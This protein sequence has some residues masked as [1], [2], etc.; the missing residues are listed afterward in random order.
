MRLH[1]VK[2]FLWACLGVAAVVIVARLLL[3]LG[4][5]TALTDA[6]PWGLW[7]GF[8]VLGGVALAAG[9]FVIAASVH[10]FHLERYRPILRPAILTAFLGYIAVA[11][12]LVFDIGVPWNI[13]RPMLFW[14]PNSALFEVAWCVMLYLS[15]LALEFSPVVL[16]R[17]PFTKVLALLKKV[18]IPLVILGVMLSTLH[19]SSL[20]TLF[21]LMPARL[22]PLWYSPLL[23]ILFLVSA[24]GLGLCTVMIESAVTSWLFRK[25]PETHL[26]S[27]LARA[28]AWVLGSYA[29]LRIGDLAV[30]GALGSLFSDPRE[31]VLFVL[32]MGTGAVL[33]IALFVLP[34]TQN[35]PAGI[36]LASVSAVLGFVLNR[37]N[38]CGLLTTGYVPA[39]TEVAITL[40]VLAGAALAFLF[41]AE[42]FSVYESPR[43][44]S[45]S[46]WPEGD[47]VTGVRLGGIWAG[48]ERRHSLAFAAGAALAFALIPGN[49]LSGASPS[50]TP[51]RGPRVVDAISSP[52]EGVTF[53]RLSAPPPGGAAAAGLADGRLHAL[54][55]D[56]NRDGRRVLF[57]HAGHQKRAGGSASC[58]LCHHANEPGA[59]ATTCAE[60]HADMY[61]ASDTF[62]HPSHV[63]KT[64]GTKGCAGCHKDPG[65]PKTR[66]SAA[67]CLDCHKEFA[68]QGSRIPP[69]VKR[70]AGMAPGY[71]SAMHGL[72]ISCHKE[73]Q[74]KTPALGAAFSQCRSCHD[75][76]AGER[77]SPGGAPSGAAGK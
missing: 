11:V 64:G 17:T 53:R 61:L 19:Q 60:C 15:V 75:P 73:A 5:T 26:F 76:K 27:G 58:R 68:S 54:S 70:F 77:P 9:G 2:M 39:W 1:L 57:D 49:V 67:S 30:R 72:C 7:I 45:D 46:P 31:S 3:G 38:V 4:A 50:R 6:T 24:V 74:Q 33:P 18:T 29:A 65:A 66:E 12:S 41:F 16:E 55:I 23:P 48:P 14:Q 51:V 36:L 32:E 42:H 35:S 44:G 8:D 71:K 20:G 28:A 52:V 10:I 43:A 62:S 22:H 25:K 13:W 47:P 40:G 59:L 63:R 21:V 69:P 37:L 56:G 34:R